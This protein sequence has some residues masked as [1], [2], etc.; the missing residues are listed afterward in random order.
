MFVKIISHKKKIR[1]GFPETKCYDCKKY[2]LTKTIYPENAVRAEGDV[3]EVTLHIDVG[4]QHQRSFDIPMK[5]HS[6][7]IMND[8]GKTVDRYSF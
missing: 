3:P 8:D 7:I 6:I 1:V 5:D 4:E 2:L